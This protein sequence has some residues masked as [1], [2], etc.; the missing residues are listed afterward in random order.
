MP[1]LLIHVFYFV[2]VFGLLFIWAG[3]RRI[4][5]PP[6]NDGLGESI[7]WGSVGIGLG[8]ILLSLTAWVFLNFN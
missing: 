6:A 5:S 8:V 2:P 7:V 3:I 1:L 4:L